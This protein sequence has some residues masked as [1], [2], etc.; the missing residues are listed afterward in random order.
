[1]DIFSGEWAPFWG[2]TSQVLTR[3]HNAMGGKASND[4]VAV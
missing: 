1:M 3:S 2:D 4:N